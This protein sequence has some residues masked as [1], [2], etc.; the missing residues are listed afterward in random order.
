MSKYI[1]AQFRFR[2]GYA[3]SLPIT[4]GNGYMRQGSVNAMVTGS[5]L[6]QPFKGLGAALSATGC[7]Q[8]FLTDDSYAGLGDGSHYG[9]GSIFQA[10]NLLFYCGAGAVTVRGIPIPDGANQ[11]QAATNL[12]YLKRIGD[13]F[14][15]G[16]FGVNSFQVG[17]PRP[18]APEVYPK[19]PPSSVKTPMN[20]AVSVVI[21]RADSNTGQTSL[22]SIPSAVVSLSAS[23]AIVKFPAA[24]SNG[25]DVWGIGVP[26]L[27]LR[28]LGNF[29]AL[30]IDIGGEVTEAVLSYSRTVEGA[31]IADGTNQVS[32]TESDPDKQFTSAD[33]GRQIVFGTYT[34]YITEVIDGTN[35]NCYDTN[36]SGSTITGDAVV[37]HA[38]DGIT[39]S[40]E[41]SWADTD[42]FGQTLAPYDAFQPPDC[43]FAGVLRDT[44]YVE[45]LYG[46]IF[47]SVPNSLS[48]PRTQRIF[49]E[50]RAVCWITTGNGYHWRVAKQSVGRLTYIGGLLPLQLELLATNI[51]VMYHQNACVGYGGRLVLW[52]GRPTMV[53]VDGSINQTFYLQAERDFE[54]WDAQTE[55]TPVVT[56]YD[57]EGLYEV[58][59]YGRTAMAVHAPT[60]N[61]C[62]PIDLTPWLDSDGSVIVGRVIIDQKLYLIEKTTANTLLVKRWNGGQGS[63]MTLQSY[64]E[65]TQRSIATVSQIEAVVQ[66]GN[67]QTSFQMD[68]IKDFRELNPISLAAIDI[69]MTPHNQVLDCQRPNV[70]GAQV[71]GVRINISGGGDAPADGHATVDYITFYGEISETFAQLGTAR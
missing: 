25:Q 2:M 5:G 22:P 33:I 17:H 53:G 41:I 9:Q 21:W 60:G 65:D 19:S 27:G 66:A 32:V 62:S 38:I 4:E 34:S 39:R 49:T 61:W 54:N 10:I 11:L 30:P 70:R 35:V 55:D 14:T 1:L 42:L 16:E 26:L 45:D 71:L 40:V 37:T 52:C 48:F 8:S 13:Y 36:S 12:S 20:A 63:V 50:D 56:A 31:S 57:P 47:Y 44:F 3:S 69:P 68:V 28:D 51:G 7:K 18:E 43:L 64:Y 15:D 29:Y 24:D 23:S 58:Y 67:R 59:V 46:T 6:I